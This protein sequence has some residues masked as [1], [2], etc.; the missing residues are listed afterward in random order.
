MTKF[1]RALIFLLSLFLV[2]LFVYT[3]YS[4]VSSQGLAYKT[5]LI[6]GKTTFIQL[7]EEHNVQPPLKLVKDK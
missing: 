4:L 7:Y 5:N 2:W 1:Q 6:T 3:R